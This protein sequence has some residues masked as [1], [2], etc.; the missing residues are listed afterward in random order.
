MNSK[1]YQRKKNAKSKLEYKLVKLM[2][3]VWW[4][5]IG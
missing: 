5:Y 3:K 1:K 2:L 4:K